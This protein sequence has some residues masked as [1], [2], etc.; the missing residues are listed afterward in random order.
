MAGELKANNPPGLYRFVLEHYRE[1]L[2]MTEILSVARGV[3]LTFR[4]L[5][6]VVL[7]LLVWSATLWTLKIY[8]PGIEVATTPATQIAV[9]TAPQFDVATIETANL[10]GIADAN[11][12]A[13]HPLSNSNIVLTGLLYGAD[14]KSYALISVDSSPE[15]AYAAGD[16]ISP[17]VSLKSVLADRVLVTRNRRIETVLLKEEHATVGSA[18]LPLMLAAGPAQDSLPQN[19]TKATEVPARR[20]KTPSESSR[21]PHSPQTVQPATGSTPA[22][23]TPTTEAAA[24]GAYAHIAPNSAR[25]PTAKTQIGTPPS[26][27]RAYSDIAPGP[28]RDKGRDP[29]RSSSR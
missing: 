15:S 13:E 18:P 12:T 3:P 14:H 7:V 9:E 17:G 8:K 26:S 29:R 24:P 5:N 22:L 10:F 11:A 27:S 4:W 2:L 21:L 16:E 1:L 20:G 25:K 23:G 28:S 6:G 19:G